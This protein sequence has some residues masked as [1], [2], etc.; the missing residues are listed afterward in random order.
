MT[1]A[2]LCPTKGRP[3]ECERMVKSVRA[4]SSMRIP[5]YL[6]AKEPYEN[7][8]HSV[9]ETE[10]TIMPEGMPTAYKWNLLAEKAMQ[11]QSIKLFMLCADDVIFTTPCWDK[12]LLDHYN[13]LENKIHVYHLRD[14]RNPAGTPHPI[15]TREYIQAMGYFLPPIFLHWFVDT[16]TVDIARL[17]GC[18]THLK[19]YEL[20]HI[21]P[22]DEG[23]PDATH[24][25]IRT[26]G[27][28][29]RD[30]WVAEKCQHFLELEKRRLMTHFIKGVVV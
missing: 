3:V 30:A 20:Q 13:A 29:Q 4:T 7:I 6:A 24:T 21:K 15:V 14:S 2:L 5:I 26:M 16:W 1:I 11:D 17:N 8:T 23:K 19:D 22:S 27:W 28:H 25:G 18:F 10:W 9:S 12:A